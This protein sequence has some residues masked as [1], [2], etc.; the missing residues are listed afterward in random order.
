M[1]T[2]LDVAASCGLDKAA[3]EEALT[4]RKY[5]SRI[6]A[7]KNMACREGIN[8]VPTFIVNERH[9]LVGA[10]PLDRFREFLKRPDK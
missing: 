3:L 10:Q 6:D 7:F 9:R 8:G 4:E 2:I 1:Q 5:A